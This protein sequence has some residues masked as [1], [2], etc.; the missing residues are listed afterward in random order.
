MIKCVLKHD[1]AL[2]QTPSKFSHILGRQEG[3]SK[4]RL[5]RRQDIRQKTDWT[6][7]SG[8]VHIHRQAGSRQANADKI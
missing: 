7:R 2:Q 3:V 1:S 8:A 5:T 4:Q 6:G